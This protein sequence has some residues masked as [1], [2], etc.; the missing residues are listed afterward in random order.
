[1]SID[2]EHSLHEVA[3]R[4][5]TTIA[6]PRHSTSRHVGA[7]VTLHYLDWASEGKPWMQ[8]THGSAHI[9]DLTALAFCDRHHIVALDQR[10][11]GDSDW[12]P[13]ATT[14]VPHTCNISKGS[15]SHG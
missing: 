3:G 15:F 4:F 9:W 14:T 12:V 5:G 1:M 6:D 7:G 10:G 11:H 13:E 8:S 2:M